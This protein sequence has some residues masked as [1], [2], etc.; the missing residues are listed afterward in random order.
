MSLTLCQGP[1][2]IIDFFLI[3]LFH[4]KGFNF[5]LTKQTFDFTF[6][7]TD[8]AFLGRL[9]RARSIGPHQDVRRGR[10]GV[11]HLRHRG[12]RRQQLAAEHHL[13]C[14]KIDFS[15]SNRKRIQLFV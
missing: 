8:G 9:R 7:V 10:V 3:S 6:S 14:K 12:H 11:A 5:F 15:N 4:L 13:Q 1:N 2:S